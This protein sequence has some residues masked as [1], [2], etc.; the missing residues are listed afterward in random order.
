MPK[1]V[2]RPDDLPDFSSPPLNEVVLGVQYSPPGG[3]QQIHV[4]D[5]W[6]L[7]KKKYPQVQEYPPIAPSFEIFGLPQSSSTSGQINFLDGPLH[8]RYWFLRPEG[9]ELI[10]FQQDRLLHNWRK[11]GDQTNEYPRF[12]AMINQFRGE[13]NQLQQYM[14][15]L[16]P[17][18]LAINQCEVSYINHIAVEKLEDAKASDWLRFVAFSN[19]EPE[20]FS[21]GFREIIRGEDG[22]PRGRLFCEALAGVKPGGQRI[23]ALTLTVRGAPNGSDI[24]SALDFITKGRELIVRRFTELTT[25][26]SHKI[27]GRV[28]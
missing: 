17:Q 19:P 6:N 5:V 15:G 8:D 13:L 18:T 23:I 20:G 14:N 26:L 2:I 11:V 3:Y 1:T 21:I 16:F 22:T 27:W 25:D 10:Q 9:D 7:F 24:E 4:S 28:K 12:E